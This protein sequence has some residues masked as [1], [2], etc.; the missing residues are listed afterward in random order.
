LAP[1][2][3]RHVCVR[4]PD[5][6]AYRDLADILIDYGRARPDSVNQTARSL[7]DEAYSGRFPCPPAPGR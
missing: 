1:D 5:F 4:L 6:I 2:S 7:A 3:K